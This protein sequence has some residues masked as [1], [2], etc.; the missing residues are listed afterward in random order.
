MIGILY[1]Y[2]DS[3]LI[4]IYNVVS[5]I[6]LYDVRN[7]V[8][9]NPSFPAGMCFYHIWTH[10]QSLRFVTA[11][12]ATITIWEVGFTAHST[13]TKVATLSVPQHVQLT[14]IFEK[15]S[16]YDT[17]CFQFIPA[18]HRLVLTGSAQPALQILAWNLENPEPLF[19]N[20]DNRFQFSR[21]FSAD[22]RFLASSTVSQEIYLWKESPTGY[23][24]AAK[25]PTS[26]QHPSSI[27]SPDGESIIVYGDSTVQL[28][29]TNAFTT[30]TTTTATATTATMTTSSTTT[31]PSASSVSTR[32][33]PT[34]DFVLEFHPI[35]PLAAFAW[36]NYNTATILD[37][38]SGLPQLTI[39]TGVRV[40]GIRVV[41]DAVIIV[42][43]REV[44]AWKLPEG[45][46]LPD[47]T[48]EPQD[49]AG[50]V[51]F[52]LSHGW[53][54]G[55]TAASISF[56]LSH[57]A[58]ITQ[59]IFGTE[60]RYL[61]VYSASTGQTI[62]YA[63]VEGETP[64]LAPGGLDIWCSVG[65]KTEV[66][67]V[68][69][70]GLHKST[71]TRPVDGGSWELPW[72]PSRGYQATK[73]GWILGPGGKRLLMLPPPLRPSAMGQVWK[74]KYLALLH[75]SLPEPI[76]LELKPLP[77]LLRPY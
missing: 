8:Q 7:S 16:P 15:F 30:T 67:T 1:W 62:G 73:Y 6:H 56:D 40:L 31:T 65:D 12:S 4:S 18:S 37:L 38:H 13:P 21:T 77:T 33:R 43:D 55:A 28:W 9:I 10:G 76:I 14:G 29:R 47:A 36:R 41:E 19:V 68:T 26:T 63:L 32:P 48:M 23:V 49:R 58:L 46:R 11:G 22:G 42:G 72:I 34:E 50:T 3:T 64:W 54:N 17:P 75:G 5:G 66:W 69:G 70:T 2:H 44:V 51:L 20:T 57:V 74:G 35:K 39:N 52:K 53:K 71:Y 45:S 59:C 60:S 24:L 61:H 27:I 25:L